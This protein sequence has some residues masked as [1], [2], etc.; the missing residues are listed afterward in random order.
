MDRDFRK[1]HIE[2]DFP[3]EPFASP[4]RLLLQSV[5]LFV[6]N[7]GLLA[8]ITLAVFLPGKLVLQF[9]C[10]VFD[11][12]TGGILSYGLLEVSDLILGALAVPAVVYGLIGRMRS[13]RAPGMGE[14]LRWGR[15]QWGK[16]LW[17]KFKV[18][19]TV[20]LW[21]LFLVVPGVVAMIKLIFTD[22]IVAIEADRERD[23]LQRSRDLSEGQRWRIFLALLPALPLDLL[24]EYAT[25]RTLQYAPA[26]MVPVD[27]LLAVLDRWMNVVILL[28]YLGMT[29]PLK[30][31]L[32]KR[33]AA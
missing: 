30:P 20:A 7:F 12:P 19:I 5:R 16:T 18:E 27:G 29:V 11:V 8:A 3:T 24:H 15:R 21:S 2:I 31:A 9:A 6:S 10:Y 22:V 32:G 25:L 1:G 28:I 33:K 13:G 23:P 26:A 14:S 4:A 17:N